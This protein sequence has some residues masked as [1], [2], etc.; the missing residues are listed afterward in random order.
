[1]GRKC[2]VFAFDYFFM[3]EHLLGIIESLEGVERRSHKQGTDLHQ[4]RQATGNVVSP[5]ENGG[6]GRF[7]LVQ[8]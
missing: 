8:P 4:V 2:L 5:P 1:M 7:I 6:Y 3:T